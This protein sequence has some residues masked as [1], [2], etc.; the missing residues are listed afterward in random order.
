[1][2]FFSGF[3]AEVSKHPYLIPADGKV[4][5]EDS[6]VSLYSLQEY[7]SRTYGRRILLIDS[8]GYSIDG[9]IKTVFLDKNR[10]DQITVFAAS[11]PGQF[12][13][14]TPHLGHGIFTYALL[15]GLSGELLTGKHPYLTIN[16]LGNYVS[17]R[18]PQ[19][20]HKLIHKQQTPYFQTDDRNFVLITRSAQ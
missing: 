11:S 1:V 6:Y 3:N 9:P 20:S 13:Y 16:D 8:C 2:M 7:L 4:G 10:D 12:A 19:L 5:K 18:V 15:E 17:K 14:E